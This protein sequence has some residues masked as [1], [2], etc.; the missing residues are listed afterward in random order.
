MYIH[1]HVIYK[2]DIYSSL[3]VPLLKTDVIPRTSECDIIW[4]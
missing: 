1:V 2:I 4:K 3:V